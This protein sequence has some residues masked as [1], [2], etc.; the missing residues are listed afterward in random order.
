MAQSAFS[1]RIPVAPGKYSVTVSH[2][3]VDDFGDTTTNAGPITVGST[4]NGMTQF[5]Y[6]KDV[7]SFTAVAGHIYVATCT[8]SVSYLCGFTVRDT[9][10]TSVATTSYGSSTTATFVATTG[11]TFTV[12][13]NPSSTTTGAWVFRLTDSG[14]DDF[15]D[16]PTTAGSGAIGVTVNGNTQ[17]SGD[18]DVVPSPPRPTGSTG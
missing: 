15:G 12:E 11:G 17:F 4:V 7:M 5:Q 16:L 14:T 1:S 18:K 3:G 10:G 6:D 13:M 9:T 2:A 8:T